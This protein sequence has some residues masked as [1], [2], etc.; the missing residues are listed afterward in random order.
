M[1]KLKE[2]INKLNA[3]KILQTEMDWAENIPEDIWKEYFEGKHIEVK[4]GLSPDMHRWYETTIS[5]ISILGKFMGVRHISNLFSEQS[6]CDDCFVHLE[7]FEM[8]EVLKPT[9]EK[10]K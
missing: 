6:S 9:Y 5:V 8:K 1:E 3:L 10:V 7:F 2:L 4:T